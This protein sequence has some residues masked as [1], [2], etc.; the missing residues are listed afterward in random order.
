MLLLGH[1]R[2]DG[3][4]LDAALTAMETLAYGGTPLNSGS[5]QAWLSGTGLTGVRSAPTPPG[6]PALTLG[7]R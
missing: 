7:F 2:D 4:P 6:A 5:A 3:D 1:G